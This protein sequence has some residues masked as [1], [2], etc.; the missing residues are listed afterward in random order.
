M[1]WGTIAHSMKTMLDNRKKL[2]DKSEFYDKYETM[3]P[4]TKISDESRYSPKGRSLMNERLNRRRSFQFVGTI[5]RTSIFTLIL[6]LFSYGLLR[7]IW[8]AIIS[9]FQ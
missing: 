6:L 2:R 4:N 5:I 1:G 3:V 9:L 7:F 8:A